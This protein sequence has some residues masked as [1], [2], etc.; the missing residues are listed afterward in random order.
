MV[1]AADATGWVRV[2]VVG[3]VRFKGELAVA[4]MLQNEDMVR[5]TFRL[6]VAVAADA[7][8]VLATSNPAPTNNVLRCFIAIS[9]HKNRTLQFLS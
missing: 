5:A 3:N 2:P 6:P 4:F 1:A 9:F 7:S 8:P